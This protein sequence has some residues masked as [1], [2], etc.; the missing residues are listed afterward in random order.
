MS[1]ARRSLLGL[2]ALAAMAPLAGVLVAAYASDSTLL[3]WTLPPPGRDALA[4]LTL[5]ANTALLV[6]GC[7]LLPGRQ[8]PAPM[9][10]FVAGSWLLVTLISTQHARMWIPAHVL[11]V[12]VAG[13]VIAAH[14]CLARLLP[15]RLDG[16]G[17]TLML[18]AVLLGG[19][20]VLGPALPS[21]PAWV[22]NLVLR[23]NPV[24]VVTTAAGIDLLRTDGFYR[25][26]P[27]AHWAFDYPSTGASLA[28][29]GVAAALLTAANRVLARAARRD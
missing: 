9:G 5:A 12:I 24:I 6:I 23:L 15:Q 7:S 10:A 8:A 14:A 29:F 16:A 2:L 26:L 20:L 21:T 19:V 1:Q 17:A 22:I 18:S 28:L 4:S 13:A 25:A 11:A 27:V 3:W